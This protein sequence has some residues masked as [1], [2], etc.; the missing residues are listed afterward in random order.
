MSAAKVSYG[1]FDRMPL[2]KLGL[3]KR[4]F[5]SVRWALYTKTKGDARTRKGWS[6]G[7]VL[8][9][10]RRDLAIVPGCGPKT[11]RHVEERLAEFGYTFAD[12]KGAP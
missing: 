7:D 9:L 8:K 5:L 11:L 1:F 2:E 10:T 6:V 3:N 12:D 4:A